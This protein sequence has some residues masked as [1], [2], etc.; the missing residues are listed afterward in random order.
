[1]T[2]YCSEYKPLTR[3]PAKVRCADCSSIHY[4]PGPPRESLSCD[5]HLAVT[6]QSLTA[7]TRCCA[8]FASRHKE[9]TA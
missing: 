9:A 4:Y 2:V 8:L 3:G 5:H 1:M 6:M 7:A